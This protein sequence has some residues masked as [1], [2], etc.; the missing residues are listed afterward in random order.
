[1]F[2]KKL[3]YLIVALNFH[4]SFIAAE[5]TVSIFIIFRFSKIR[6]SSTDIV[7][8]T[9]PTRCRLFSGRC[10]H[11]VA[12]CHTFFSWSQDELVAFASSFNNASSRRLPS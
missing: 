7:S 8:S 1:M 5:S 4:R 11:A 2:T 3:N 10:R 12:L 6:V 9:S